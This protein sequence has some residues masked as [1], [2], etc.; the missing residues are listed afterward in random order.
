MV[1]LRMSVS[2][3]IAVREENRL[4]GSCVMEVASIWRLERSVRL[5]NEEGSAPARICQIV[6]MIERKDI[7]GMLLPP[8]T[9]KDLRPVS[10]PSSLGNDDGT[11][12]NV[13]CLY[14]GEW[15]Y[16][17]FRGMG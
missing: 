9:C 5:V 15:E 2:V 4:S 16:A 3:V 11:P 14:V 8:M 7:P 6:L 10:A 13:N 1:G 17:K 12:G